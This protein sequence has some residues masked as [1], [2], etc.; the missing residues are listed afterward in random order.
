MRCIA[1]SGRVLPIYQ[2]PVIV[3]KVI[4]D[5]NGIKSADIDMI[6]KPEAEGSGGNITD[7]DGHIWSGDRNI[8]IGGGGCKDLEKLGKINKSAVLGKSVSRNDSDGEESAV[9]KKNSDVEVTDL[10]MRS[11][12]VPEP[13]A[14]SASPN[15]RL[16]SMS[17]MSSPV[18]YICKR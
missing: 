10:I 17:S 16:S 14:P 8:L 18:N 2:H 15:P 6:L 11:S 7:G 4:V 1:G 5:G 3:Q 12:P 13:N 9:Q